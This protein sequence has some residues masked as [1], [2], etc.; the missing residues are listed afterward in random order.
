MSFLALNDLEKAIYDCISSRIDY[1]NALYTKVNQPTLSHLQLVQNAAALLLTNTRRCENVIPILLSLHWLPV[2]FRIGFK[3]K[4]T[5]NGLAPLS[6][7][8]L[9]DLYR[10]DR[11]LRSSDS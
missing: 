1:C 8:E 4:I 6:W 11:E 7:T 3:L 9:L 2:H 10:P 5:L